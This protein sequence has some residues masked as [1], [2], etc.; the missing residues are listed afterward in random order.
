[1][2]QARERGAQRHSGK[3]NGDETIRKSLFMSF[4]L[5]AGLRTLVTPERDTYG[6]MGPLLEVLMSLDPRLLLK[7]PLKC[8]VDRTYS[9][10]NRIRCFLYNGAKLVH[11][12]PVQSCNP[13]TY[14]QPHD[15]VAPCI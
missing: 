15:R 5:A 10:F 4:R 2:S 7:L 13:K 1:M 8:F 12:S 11:S 14:R 6:V 9:S 3:G